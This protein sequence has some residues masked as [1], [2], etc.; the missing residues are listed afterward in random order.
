[1]KSPDSLSR[2][3]LDWRRSLNLSEKTVTRD[4]Y[5]LKRFFLW[6]DGRD[7]RETDKDTVTDYFTHLKSMKSG[8]TGKP[9]SCSSLRIELLSL[10]EFF[11][12]LLTRGTILGNPFEGIRIKREKHEKERKIFTEEEMARFLDSIPVTNPE[13]CLFRAALELMYSSAL[14]LSE[15]LHL[16]MGHVN[17]EERVLL[18]KQGK[19]KKDRYV[20]FSGTALVF[21]RHYLKSGRR[22]YLSAAG[23]TAD[24]EY[25]F[26]GAGG[27]K[28]NQTHFRRQFHRY[29]EASGLSNRGFTPHSI[30]HAAA[31]HLLK[32][33]AGI[34]Y[35][36]E[37]LGHEDLKTTQGYTRP[38]VENIKAVYRTFHP[39]ENEYFREITEEYL[40]HLRELKEKLIRG[41]E[42]SA[43]YRRNGTV[44]G[45]EKS[46]D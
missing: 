13:D 20:P 31:T 29:L 7:L 21:L 26:P 30:R 12:F 18:V 43:Y 5:Y 28:R 16:E 2:E 15:V 44:K 9:L 3:F 40:V 25:V 36:Q 11:S 23:R 35:V 14:R 45:F 34:R 46:E 1:M 10:N 27:K 38:E 22:E 37:L 8:K 17:L 24:E 19:G 42:R 32:H 33:G 4:Y 39:R 41:K 6:L